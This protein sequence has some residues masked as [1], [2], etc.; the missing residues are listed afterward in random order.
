MVSRWKSICHTSIRLS[1][2]SFPDDNLSKCQWIFIKLGMCIDIVKIFLGGLLMGK[3]CQFLTACHTSL[4]AFY[5]PPH[6]SGG[7]WFHIGSPSVLPLSVHPD[8]HFRMITLNQWIFTKLGMCIDIVEIWFGI[9]NG[10]I[11][12]IYDRVIC[13]LHD[14]GGVSS[15]HNTNK[16]TLKPIDQFSSNFTWG[17]L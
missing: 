8:F 17:L 5:T 6:N 7:I 15:F 16:Q 2:F 11:L 10:Q 14:S 13:W 3:F 4:F 12:S 1:V 9:A